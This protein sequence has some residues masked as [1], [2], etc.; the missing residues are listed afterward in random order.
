[1]ENGC[2][3][4][5]LSGSV[6]VLLLGCSTLAPR[7]IAVDYKASAVDNQ[8]VG[9]VEVVF[10]ERVLPVLPL[11]DAAFHN[12]AV[13][14]AAPELR[15]A[16]SRV[17]ADMNDYLAEQISAVTGVSAVR[18]ENPLSE[19]PW[20][21]FEDSTPRVVELAQRACLRAKTT[22]VVIPTFRVRTPGIG[23]LGA[24]NLI[25]GRLYVFDDSGVR[26]GEA[27]YTSDYTYLRGSD[28]EGYESTLLMG[29][30]SFVAELVPLLLQPD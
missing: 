22:F 18:V 25:E 23:P 15:E 27:H 24:S 11:I 30:R 1:M 10:S 21:M 28:V 12:A 14:S 9:V 16:D 6:V 26:V 4:F 13:Q 3:L 8:A 5:L 20:D 2:R 19:V 17:Q 7:E 29:Y